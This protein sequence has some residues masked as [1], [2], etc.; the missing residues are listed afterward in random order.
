M[1]DFHNFEWSQRKDCGWKL[2]WVHRN[3]KT[4]ERLVKCYWWYC[5]VFHIFQEA[6]YYLSINSVKCL[7]FSLLVHL[8]CF[9]YILSFSLDTSIFNIILTKKIKLTFKN[10]Q[11]SQIT[12]HKAVHESIFRNKI[13]SMPENLLSAILKCGAPKF[14]CIENI[15]LHFIFDSLNNCVWF[16]ASCFKQNLMFVS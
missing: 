4:Y 14:V 16:G 10:G 11:A 7:I 15:I 1:P 3:E 6:G 9:I 12:P 2:D 5:K 8:Y 13:C